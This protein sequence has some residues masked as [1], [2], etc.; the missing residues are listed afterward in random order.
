MSEGGRV[1]PCKT[2]HLH[3]WYI[4][5]ANGVSTLTAWVPPAATSYYIL[6]H[7]Y[8]HAYLGRYTTLPTVPFLPIHYPLAP[9]FRS[10]FWPW[11]FLQYGSRV[12]FPIYY[13]DSPVCPDPHLPSALTTPS[14]CCCCCCRCCSLSFRLDEDHTKR[15]FHMVATLPSPASANGPGSITN[16]YPSSALP[17][18]ITCPPRL[19]RPPRRPDQADSLY[20][21]H[22]LEPQH[23]AA[24]AFEPCDY[25]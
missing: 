11:N 9:F 23:L 5:R 18:T 17:L 24:G 14:E 20:S 10:F 4:H 25:P 15:D 6:L 22:Q 7:T 16:P 13:D 2:L 21:H 19:P 8:L 3:T 1:L 12:A